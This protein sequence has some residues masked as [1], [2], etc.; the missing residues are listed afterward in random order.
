MGNVY[1]SVE[2]GPMK[3]LLITHQVFLASEALSG[4]LCAIETARKHGAA[5]SFFPVRFFGAHIMFPKSSS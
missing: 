1:T 5:R 4:R 3:P 2:V